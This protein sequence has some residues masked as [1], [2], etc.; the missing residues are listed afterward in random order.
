MTRLPHAKQPHSQHR[1][2]K[3]G[4]IGVMFREEKLLIIRRSLTV[5]APGKLCLPGGGIEAGESE[6]EALVREMQEELTIDVTPRRLCWRSVTP[7]GTRLAW[8]LA[9]FPDQVD[10]VPNPEEVSE[11]HWMTANEIVQARGTLP[12]LPEFVAAWRKSE[13]DLPWKDS[14]QT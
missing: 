6:E 11:V 1:S 12:S 7:W 5:N 10:P 4:V 9:E 2:R 8:W 14:S 3:R 13:I